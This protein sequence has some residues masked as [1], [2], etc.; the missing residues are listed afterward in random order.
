MRMRSSARSHSGSD[1][2]TYSRTGTEFFSI[3]CTKMT[4]KPASF[5]SRLTRWGATSPRW[6]TNLTL[7][8]AT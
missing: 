6:A 8:F 7:R 4:S 5:V 2:R 1:I 3:R